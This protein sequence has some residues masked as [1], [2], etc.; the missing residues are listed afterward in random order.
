MKSLEKF[1]VS[2]RNRGEG[3]WR[4]AANT[5]THLQPKGFQEPELVSFF[6]ELPA[7]ASHKGFKN[8][9]GPK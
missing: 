1:H 5:I 3:G 6:A 9:L 7:A 4:T 8:C 2:T